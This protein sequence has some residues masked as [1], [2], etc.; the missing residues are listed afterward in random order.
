M[1][2]QSFIIH[3]PLIDHVYSTIHAFLF[4]QSSPCNTS[5]KSAKALLEPPSVLPNRLGYLLLYSTSIVL[6]VSFHTL[7]TNLTR[8]VGLASVQALLKSSTIHSH[9]DIPKAATLGKRKSSDEHSRPDKKKIMTVCVHSLLKMPLFINLILANF[10]ELT[11]SDH[12]L[13]GC[14]LG[15]QCQKRA[16]LTTSSLR[17]PT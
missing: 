16:W 1:P 3:E 10:A 4:L 9:A 15:F 11:G 2:N 17:R 14:H 13:I 12:I 5:C 8:Q 7:T 6:A